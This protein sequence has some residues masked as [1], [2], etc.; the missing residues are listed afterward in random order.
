MLNS[1]QHNNATTESC[2]KHK[3]VP[4]VE[5]EDFQSQLKVSQAP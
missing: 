1:S 3:Q 5:K 4:L 2:L